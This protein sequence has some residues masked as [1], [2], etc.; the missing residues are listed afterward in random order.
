MVEQLVRGA[1]RLSWQPA[2]FACSASRTGSH[3]FP[4]NI[5]RVGKMNRA[6]SWSQLNRSWYQGLGYFCDRPDHAFI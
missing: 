3:L 2:E 4:C 5:T 6:R 1:E